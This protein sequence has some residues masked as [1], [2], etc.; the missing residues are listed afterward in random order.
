MPKWRNW[1][2]RYLEGVVP[3]GRAGSTPAFGTMFLSVFPSR[4]V[5][6]SPVAAEPKVSDEVRQHISAGRIP[7]IGICEISNPLSEITCVF[8]R[9]PVL[10]VIN[11]ASVVA[12]LSKRVKIHET[13]NFSYCRVYNRELQPARSASGRGRFSRFSEGTIIKPP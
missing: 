5:E 10:P 11:R 13:G 4:A 6:I 2:T 9:Y 7:K 12:M 3:Y 8:H 1:Q